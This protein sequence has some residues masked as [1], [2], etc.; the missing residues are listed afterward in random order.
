MDGVNKVEDW[1]FST[2][3]RYVKTGL[4]SK[5]WA[6]HDEWSKLWRIKPRQNK[7]HFIEATISLAPHLGEAWHGR[8]LSANSPTGMLKLISPFKAYC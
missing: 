1:P 8:L 6:Y 7:K 4:L 3:H 5:D 2:F